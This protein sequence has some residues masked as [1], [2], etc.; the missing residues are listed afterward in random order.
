MQLCV[1]Y[2]E[3]FKED[4]GVARIERAGGLVGKDQL[5][6][7]D[8]GAR[9]GHA[10]ALAARHLARIF[11]QNVRHAEHVRSAIDLRA[12]GIGLLALDGKGQGDVLE[13]GQGVQQVRVLEDE[14]QVVATELGELTAA[15]LRD[16]EPVQDDV[17]AG[18]GI[19]GGDA[20]Q[21]RALTR[22]RWTHHADELAFADVERHVVERACDGLAR[23]VDLPNVAHGEQDVAVVGRARVRDACRRGCGNHGHGDSFLFGSVYPHDAALAKTEPSKGLTA[24]LRFCKVRRRRRRRAVRGRIAVCNGRRLGSRQIHARAVE[25]EGQRD[26]GARSLF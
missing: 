13:T 16:V 4:C 12:D 17:P 18:H 11:L 24:N 1:Q 2:L 26:G 19:D 3:G 21:K 15:Q 10:L 6:V 5:R 23:A 25:G 20:V 9:R 22:A 14:A 7:S 8:D